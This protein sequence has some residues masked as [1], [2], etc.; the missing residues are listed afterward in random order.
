MDHMVS[1]WY[2]SGNRGSLHCLYFQRFRYTLRII[3]HI[4]YCFYNYQQ[5]ACNALSAAI[6][7]FCVALYS[8]SQIYTNL[9]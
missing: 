4:R 7:E 1:W 3:I 5:L 8:M 6:F 2:S 9:N